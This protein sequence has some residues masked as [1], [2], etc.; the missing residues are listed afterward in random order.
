MQ[1]TTSVV[2]I[3]QAAVMIQQM[4]NRIRTAADELN[5]QPAMRINCADYFDEEDVQRIG[6]YIRRNNKR[7]K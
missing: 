5:I 3:G 4:P 6:E 2:S 1:A 7:E